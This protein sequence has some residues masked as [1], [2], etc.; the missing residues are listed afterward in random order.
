MEKK[1]YLTP[2]VE[3]L[4]FMDEM[5]LLAGTGGPSY[6]GDEDEINTGTPGTVPPGTVINF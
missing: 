3:I 6:S 5:A 1:A 2:E 4:E